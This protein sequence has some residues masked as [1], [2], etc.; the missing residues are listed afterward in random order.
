MTV[1]AP[2][3]GRVEE[4]TGASESDGVFYGVVKGTARPFRETGL[5][6]YDYVLLPEKEREKTQTRRAENRRLRPQSRTA[7]RSRARRSSA[8]SRLT[9][10]AP[11]EIKISSAFF[12]TL[13]ALYG[14]W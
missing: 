11:A 12:I 4:K 10:R 3:N 5:D 8:R 1:V 14:F 6:I 2:T 7:A 13:T 9:L